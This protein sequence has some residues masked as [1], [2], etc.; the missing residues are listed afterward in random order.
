MSGLLLKLNED[1]LEG[2]YIEN[3]ISSCSDSEDLEAYFQ[4]KYNKELQAIEEKK[5]KHMKFQQVFSQHIA[6]IDKIARV[7]TLG[8]IK[9][10]IKDFLKVSE[11]LDQYDLPGIPT[12][13]KHQNVFR[14]ILNNP[15]LAE[16]DFSAAVYEAFNSLGYRKF[17]LEFLDDETLSILLS[18]EKF[19]NLAK[20]S[21]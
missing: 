18:D 9:Q 16:S 14:V 20:I 8:E 11:S 13:N 3:S 1:L 21:I 12:N 19:L 15:R 2:S 17:I 10:N 7:N 6:L 4:E 5:I